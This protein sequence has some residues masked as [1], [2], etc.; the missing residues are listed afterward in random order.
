MTDAAKELAVMLRQEYGKTPITKP[1]LVQTMDSSKII[2]GPSPS[3]SAIEKK[4][5]SL[6]SVK[7]EIVETKNLPVLS[8]SEVLLSEFSNEEF[9]NVLSFK[10]SSFIS[11][12]TQSS[13]NFEIK[14]VRA[15][16]DP[17]LAIPG[18]NRRGGFRCPVG[19]RYGGQIT[20]RF[21]RSCGW[22]VARRIANQIADIGERLEQRD[23]GKRKRRLDRRNARMVRR[24]GGVPETGRVE[25]GLRGIADRLDG[26][27]APKPRVGR[28]GIPATGR[29]EG[30]LRGIAE[31]LEGG[32]RPQPRQPR[33]EVDAPSV[34]RPQNRRRDVI[35][36]TAP[37]P[38][39]PK[40][41]RSEERED[42]EFLKRIL[43]GHPDGEEGPVW[44]DWVDITK[45]D[46]PIIKRLV[47]KGFLRQEMNDTP[48]GVRPDPDR[49]KYSLE[50]TAAG[51]A[52]LNG[53]N[54]P[55][56]KPRPARQPAPARPRPQARPRVAPQPANVD[57]LTAR[58]ASDAGASE[59]FKPYVLRKYDEYA[60]RVREIRAGGGNAGMLTRR[61]WYAINKPNLRDAWKDAHG[62]SA[63]QDF[64][65]PTPQARRPRNNRGR[66]KKATTAG[67]GRSATRKPTPDDVP[68]PAPAKPVRPARPARRP[69]A[70]PKAAGKPQIELDTNWTRKPNGIWERDGYKVKPFF[71][72]DGNLK[73]MDIEAPDGGQNRMLYGGDQSKEEI[74]N[75]AD[76][77]YEMAVKLEAGRRAQPEQQSGQRPVSRE[78]RRQPR[79]KMPDFGG[80]GWDAI[81]QPDGSTKWK[82]GN[83]E[84]ELL[85]QESGEFRGFLA[86]NIV[87]G[88]GIEQEYRGSQGQAS[89]NRY[90]RDFSQQLLDLSD[91]NSENQ[92]SPTPPEPPTPRTP[93]KAPKAKKVKALNNSKDRHEKRLPKLANGELFKEVEVGNKGIRTKAQALAYKGPLNDIPD[94]FLEDV[95]RKRSDFV[96]T[97]D[98]YLERDSALRKIMFPVLAN[99]MI[100]PAQSAAMRD[101][102]GRIKKSRTKES[103][104]TDDDKKILKK[105]KES[106]VDHISY[107]AGTGGANPSFHLFIGDDGSIDG[108]GYL[109]KPKD[110]MF[111]NGANHA[112]LLGAA[113]AERMGFAQGQGRLMKGV[114]R[115]RVRTK[116]LLELGPNFAEGIA[117]NIGDVN[118]GAD[119][120]TDKESRLA[121][122]LINA[123]MG[124]HDRHSGN[125]MVFR[126]NGALPIDFGRAFY[127]QPDTPSEMRN[128]L[129]RG[130]YQ[131][132]DGDLMKGYKAQF[133]SLVDGGMNVSD[134]KAQVR[135]ELKETLENWHD[136][137]MEIVAN[138]GAADALGSRF[139][140]ARDVGNA[141]VGIAERKRVVRHRIGVMKSDEF[142]NLLT[143]SFR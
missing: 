16:W 132:I 61:E 90:L 86:R 49:A 108:R 110:G 18:T 112:E 55:A 134:A 9:R 5:A 128:Y 19:T 92:S 97:N 28:G 3:G 59:D 25:G 67:A 52:F 65:P 50:V 2:E 106:G 81:N 119:A 46:E 7:S 40:G 34:R 11:D 114:D 138:G 142:I 136:G 68:E 41:N 135:R 15:I 47:E 102:I 113:L 42:R 20:D 72:A 87:D 111:G 99:D 70:K 79:L 98:G 126:G 75:A 95:L 125:G 116:I 33:P 130:Q 69:A 4:V 53:R 127:E 143:E 13:F 12:Q 82:K 141:R 71:D 109:L 48:A 26:G 64:E 96:L 66:R 121:A 51:K 131:G 44:D 10:A 17:S 39:R 120:I 89:L 76:S 123:I 73:R 115:G 77:L 105:L 103:P 129:L 78:L 107:F 63:P 58:D 139:A 37:T 62:R 8:I 54:N 124:S 6:T 85:P 32:A 45:E 83:W 133:R 93:P 30:G 94:K 29:V 24:L 35:P 60:K 84:I 43:N 74:Q 14:G 140:D 36:E 104:L 118:G 1:E 122:G 91:G 88:D 117:A 31:R 137:M 38:Q 80:A 56:P 21:G 27:D 101:F 57:V 23:D 100:S 22:G